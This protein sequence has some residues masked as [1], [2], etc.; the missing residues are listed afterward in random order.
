MNLPDP[1]DTNPSPPGESLIETTL[2]RL[3]EAQYA[4]A[5]A[6]YGASDAPSILSAILIFGGKTYQSAHLA[7]IEPD[8]QPPMLRV[9]ARRVGS[10]ILAADELRP[11][12]S[13]PAYEALGAVEYLHAANIEEDPFLTEAERARMRA[14]GV[15][16]MLLVPLVIGQTLNGLIYMTHGAPVHTPVETLRALR[17]LADQTAVVFENRALLR[18]TELNLGETQTLYALNQALLAAQDPLELL[19]AISRHLADDADSIMHIVASRRR[20]GGDDIAVQHIITRRG[21]QVVNIPLKG[22]RASGLFSTPSV[23]V[24]FVENVLD[25]PPDAPLLE[26]LRERTRSYAAIIAR[27]ADRTTDVVTVAYESPRTFDSRARRLFTASAEQ[28]NIVLQNQ[29]LLFESQASA[30]RLSRQVRVL[31]SLNRLAT[32]ISS[33]QNEKQ[34]LDYVTREMHDAVNADHV[35][36]VLV[37]QMSEVGTVVSE[38]PDQG[39]VGAPV[40]MLNSPLVRALLEDPNTPFIVNNVETDAMLTTQTRAALK[41]VGTQALMV[42]P[43]YVYG[44]FIGTVGFDVY[45]RGRTFT[46]DM[47]DLAQTM[48]S[49]LAIALQNIRLFTEAQQRAAQLQ[50]VA[51]LGQELQSSLETESV[52]R[53][54]LSGAPDVLRIDH[55]TITL[56]DDEAGTL[57]VVGTNDGGMVQLTLKNGALVS[58][59]ETTAG[60]VWS[61]G[62]SVFS[63]TPATSMTP[64]ASIMVVPIRARDHR[65]GA[66]TISAS[67]ASSYSETDKAIFQQ[68]VN[69]L[70]VALEN[71]DA[72][73]RSQRTARSEALV[74]EVT[75]RFQQFSNIDGLVTTAVGELGRAL[76]A[77]RARV[78]LIAPEDAADSASSAA[79][80]GAGT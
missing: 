62:T 18:R 56:Y 69:L 79:D 14:D 73:T 54:M 39:I 42:L 43:L 49:Q 41:T 35:G 65:L 9:V 58:V 27:S 16:A 75:G 57:R 72:Y 32:G 26:L 50:G 37:E 7:F 38:Y 17:N 23:E 59:N 3:A 19:R 13:Y 66:V 48:T 30:D 40:D 10:A 47:I 55:M 80:Q 6:I 63:V 11:L 29:R 60:Q 22:M 15:V 76:G 52:L 74:N 77:R 78:R 53:T 67:G 20:D 71:A 21:E 12:D 24:V 64:G 51:A 31:Q 2:S 1:N 34:L 28:L 33:F 68:I 36:V 25:P 5:S 44:N 70:A 8:V 61:S 45:E 46:Q 4:A